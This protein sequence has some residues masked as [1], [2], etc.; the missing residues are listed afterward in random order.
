KVQI[1]ASLIS[2]FLIPVWVDS[3]V[4][5]LIYL[6]ASLGLAVIVGG[7][8]SLMP[9][10]RMNRNLELVIIPLSISLLVLAALI[11]RQLGGI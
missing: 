10:Y 8:E 7:V 9:R 5:T 2:Y 4:I 3:A 11:V 1:Y 6:A